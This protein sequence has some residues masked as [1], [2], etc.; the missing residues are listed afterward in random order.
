MQSLSHRHY[1]SLCVYR[2]KF[3]FDDIIFVDGGGD[4]L[5]LESSDANSGSEYV[6]SNLV[7]S[8]LPI[9]DHHFRTTDPFKGGDSELLKSIVGLQGVWKI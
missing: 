3:H 5:I 4:S 8:F 7:H 1:I 2:E 9:A 6:L